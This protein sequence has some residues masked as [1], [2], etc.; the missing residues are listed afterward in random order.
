MSLM[1]TALLDNK[2]SNYRSFRDGKMRALVYQQG[3]KEV[4]RLHVQS[5]K[6]KWL[7]P[8]FLLSGWKVEKLD[9]PF[10]KVRGLVCV[11]GADG[12]VV[13]R[14]RQP[15]KKIETCLCH[16]AK[17]ELAYLGTGEEASKVTGLELP[18]FEVTVKQRH[19]GFSDVI[20]YFGYK[21]M[22]LTYVV[23][24]V[25]NGVFIVL[26][27]DEQGKSKLVNLKRGD[28]GFKKVKAAWKKGVGL[29]RVL[30][31]KKGWNEGEI[32]E[33]KELQIEE[34]EEASEDEDV[35]S[36]E[37]VTQR[38]VQD[39]T[40]DQHNN[41]GPPNDVK[42]LRDNWMEPGEE[43]LPDA[44][45]VFYEEVLDLGKRNTDRVNNSNSPLMSLM[46]HIGIIID[47]GTKTTESNRSP[48][49]IAN[50]F[51][52]ESDV[53]WNGVP[54]LPDLPYLPV[55]TGVG[56]G[57]EPTAAFASFGP[58]MPLP[59]DLVID[60]PSR[61][62]PR[63][64]HRS[65]EVDKAPAEIANTMAPSA[66]HKGKGSNVEDG[67]GDGQ[68]RKGSTLVMLRV[69]NVLSCTMVN[70]DSSFHDLAKTVLS[71]FAR[72][73]EYST[74]RNLLPWKSMEE[75]KEWVDS[76]SNNVACIKVETTADEV[77]LFYDDCKGQ[78]APV[79]KIFPSFGE[80]TCTVSFCWSKAS[81]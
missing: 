19:D 29:D 69:K 59:T 61:K 23:I 27:V 72:M 24:D 45:D 76:D 70:T 60:G 40:Q 42:V 3:S 8:L 35:E 11:E 21:L 34:E 53:I 74:D 55:Q 28:N 14:F 71:K 12:N 56:E 48:R 63:K 58:D 33:M 31:W 66:E 77:L 62:K 65:L 47:G 20:S 75:L 7:Q 79:K 32:E 39:E 30:V 6:P 54:G 57:N 15:L 22:G 46:A 52:D 64:S 44:L 10:V 17:V 67:V 25:W 68:R 50:H 80:E 2:G 16:D 9:P 36:A 43:E 51:V 13:F 78:T 41:E 1:L 4:P 38:D 18:L 81:D 73:E 5:K 49:S 26:Q 37:A